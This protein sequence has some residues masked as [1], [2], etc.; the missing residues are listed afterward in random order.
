MER[1][2]VELGVGVFLLIGLACL[3]YVSFHL[4]DINLWNRSNYEIHARFSDVAGLKQKATVTMAGVQI[5]QV[6]NIGLKD[7]QAWITFSIDKNVQLEEDSIASIKTMGLIGD[8]YV[9]ISPGGSDEYIKPGGILRETQPPLDIEN[10]LGRF[11][12]GG[13]EKGQTD[14]P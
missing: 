10:L 7:G 14:K 12:F 8:K 1:K 4:G 9:S 11:V 5:G 6:K 13:M 2:S 3:G